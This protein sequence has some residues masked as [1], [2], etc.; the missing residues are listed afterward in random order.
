L[1]GRVEIG[2]FVYTEALAIFRYGGGQQLSESGFVVCHGRGFFV[3]DDR[4]WGERY[5]H[6]AV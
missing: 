2:A 4:V 5:V 1:L 6:G 3:E